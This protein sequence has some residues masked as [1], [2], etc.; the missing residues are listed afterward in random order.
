MQDDLAS[1]PDNNRRREWAKQRLGCLKRCFDVG[2]T[3][4]RSPETD[5][6]GEAQV[7]RLLVHRALLCAASVD[8]YTTTAAMCQRYD[9]LDHGLV[10]RIR[11]VCD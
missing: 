7:L 6:V 11:G 2:E 3:T 9:L 4:K 1:N 10:R 5:D 8:G